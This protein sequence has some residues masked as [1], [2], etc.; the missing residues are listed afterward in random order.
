M[1]RLMNGAAPRARCALRAAAWLLQHHVCARKLR[2][3]VRGACA[4]KRAR[5]V[6]AKKRNEGDKVV[7]DGWLDA[8]ARFVV[9]H[10]RW[11]SGAARLGD[12]SS[13]STDQ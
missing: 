1:R 7:T 10:K 5:A 3:C 13:A 11:C 12:A 9:S 6:H 8:D 2:A 4:R